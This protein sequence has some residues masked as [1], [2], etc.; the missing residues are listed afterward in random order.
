MTKCQSLQTGILFVYIPAW[1]VECF[2]YPAVIPGS[3]GF[4]ETEQLIKYK[5][6]D[7]TIG[8]QSRD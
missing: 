2:F 3:S 7:Q 8:R 5:K 6:Y 4:I 1:R